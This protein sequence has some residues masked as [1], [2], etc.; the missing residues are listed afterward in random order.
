MDVYV[1][2]ISIQTDDSDMKGLLSEDETAQVLKLLIN[3]DTILSKE[4]GFIGMGDHNAADTKL[5]SLIGRKVNDKII[6]VKNISDLRSSDPTQPTRAVGQDTTALSQESMTTLQNEI[7]SLNSQL[8]KQDDEYTKLHDMHKK[9]S[10]KKVKLEEELEKKY[11]ENMDLTKKVEIAE[12][13]TKALKKA[14]SPGLSRS[15]NE[16]ESLKEENAILKRKLTMAMEKLED[17]E[18]E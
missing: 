5:R 13:E 4:I 9:I 1:G 16:S 7:S 18:D 11:N 12:N 3:P 2:H 14:A 15:E 10:R 6:N 17:Y 8:D